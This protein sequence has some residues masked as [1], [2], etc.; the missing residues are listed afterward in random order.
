MTAPTHEAG[1]S[2]RTLP[3]ATAA[4]GRDAPG[5]L[6]WAL[7]GALGCCGAVWAVWPPTST[8]VRGPIP[9]IGGA[10]LLALALRARPLWTPIGGAAAIVAAVVGVVW[11][12]PTIGRAPILVALAGV[13][14]AH[15]ALGER[16]WPSRATSA[17]DTPRWTALP[18]IVAAEIVWYRTLSLSAAA[19]LLGSAAAVALISL[20][21]P[22]I[23]RR[24][25]RAIE[26]V[27]PRAVRPWVGVA[28]ATGLA[29]A[30]RY[31]LGRWAAFRAWRAVGLTGRDGSL[32]GAV[33]VGFALRTWWVAEKT[34]SNTEFYTHWN[35]EYAAQFARGETPSYLGIKTALWPIGYAAT[36]APLQWFSTATEWFGIHD[37][38]A[39]LNVVAGTSTILLAAALASMWFGPEARNP[40][41]WL[42]AIATGHIYA[43]SAA[44]PEVVVSAVFVLVALAATV[45][46]R[47][48]APRHR[49]APY[50]T[51]GLL[52]AYGAFLK[53]FGNFLLIVPALTIRSVTGRWT[54]AFRATLATAAGALVLLMPWAIRNSVQ[55]GLNSPF[56]TIAADSLC[57]TTYDI[58]WTRFIDDANQAGDFNAVIPSEM[59][60]DCYRYSPFDN[61][62]SEFSQSVPDGKFTYDHPDEARW[63]RN[64]VNEF[65]AWSIRHPDHY[66]RVAPIRLFTTAGND[67]EGGLT[68][69]TQS[70]QAEIAGPLA[71]RVFQDGANAWYYAVAGLAVAAL[72]LL[73]SARRAIPLWAIPLVLA[74]YPIL[75]PRALSRHFFAAYPFLAVLAG[76]TIA[77]VI[78]GARS[79]SSDPT[80]S[81]AGTEP[82]PTRR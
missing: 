82:D 13:G 27:R 80:T 55:V 63:Y 79:R 36:I 48:A 24:I 39:A 1:T 33:V 19:V 66:V 17:P 68:L 59:L 42:M 23:D 2:G 18:V 70:G 65:L 7:I 29:G 43:T 75:G 11:S 47:R 15:L 3:P 6:T 9:V 77:A 26:A 32:L 22:G 64:E 67:D 72:A 10:L 28:E 53:D 62:A 50:V 12:V 5:W 40:T 78:V 35:L 58:D 74:T 49:Y 76:A 44:A 37:A 52:V 56:P 38:A 45:I 57:Y 25:D 51:L 73:R 61:P 71:M 21:H 4:P 16:R 54:G 30:R 20:R 46:A 34:T 69:A 31:L 41:A 14:V 81:E 8:Y 60:N